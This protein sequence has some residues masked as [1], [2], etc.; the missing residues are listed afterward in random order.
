M[1]F[2]FGQYNKHISS[3]DAKPVIFWVFE[4]ACGVKKLFLFFLLARPPIENCQ[5][6]NIQ[7]RKPKTVQ[8]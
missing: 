4:G 6:K 3:K 7:A 8:S 5:K 2:E 1:K